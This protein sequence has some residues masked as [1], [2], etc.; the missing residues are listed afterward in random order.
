MTYD[1]L[2]KGPENHLFEIE[3]RKVASLSHSFCERVKV[4]LQ[5]AGALLQNC[6]PSLNFPLEK[7]N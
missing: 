6:V 1:C 7:A 4:Q 5:H 2:S 3:S